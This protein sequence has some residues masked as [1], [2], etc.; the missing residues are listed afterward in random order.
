MAWEI[1]TRKTRRSGSPS[2]TFNKLGRLSLNKTATTMLEKD[3]VEFVLLLWDAT[4]R[5]VGVKPV[6]RKDARAYKLAYGKKGN[7][8]GF[9]AK[10]FM[11]YI[12]YDYSESR[13]CPVRWDEGESMFIGELPADFLIKNRQQ[14]LLAM[15]KKG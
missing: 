1:F 8:A 14:Q 4:K 15:G 12:G 3:A 10:T 2:I 5:Q 6:T 11:D 13:S 7:G 9:S